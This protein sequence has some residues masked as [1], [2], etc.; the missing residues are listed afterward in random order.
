MKN[1]TFKS[2]IVFAFIL[3][4]S[5]TKMDAQTVT[6]SPNTTQNI[7]TGGT[8]SLTAT[9]SGNNAT[10]PGGNSN[11]TYTWSASPAAGVS[12]TN[13][14]VTIT[15]NNSSTVATF[16]S[17]GT[18]LITCQVQ[19][20]GGGLTATS[21]ATTVIVTSPV[22]SV[23]LTPSGAQNT[24]VGGSISFT[25]AATNFGGSGNYTYTWT[26]AGATIPGSNPNGI[27]GA[28]DTK[29]LTFP[30]AGTFTVSV[31]I[32]RTGATTLT[33]ST[34]TVTVVAANLWASSSTGSQVSSYVVNNGAYIAGPTNLFA[35]SFPGTTTGGT[36]S[37]ALARN[38]TPSA[39]NG[40][41]Y[42]L[43]NTSGNNG[44][45]E[46]FAA[47]STG[48]TPTRIGSVDINGGSNNALGFVRLGVGPDGTAW[49]LAGDNTNLFLASFMTNGINPVTITTK[50]VSLSGGLV[51]TFQNGDVCVSGN[52]N[53]Y[54]LANDGAG[55]TQIFIG[56]LS[57]PTVTLTKKWDLRDENNAA[58]TGTVNGVAFDALG[59]LYIT[60]GSGLY[61]INQA[62]VFG[63][64]VPTVQCSLVDAQTGLQ[65]LASNVFPQ[66]STLPVTLGDF[67]VVRQGSNA[68]L[69][70]TTLT[71]SN[72]DHFEIE[73]SSDGV[74]FSVAGT[75]G[76]GTNSVVIKN[77][78]YIDPINQNSGMIYY[79]LRTVDKDGHGVYSKVITLRIA[80]GLVKD[81]S[82]FPNPFT[83]SLT[84][85]I[86]AEKATSV[87]VR[88]SNA[89]GQPV[90]NR[91][92]ALNQGE[93]TV[94]LQSELQNLKPGM[95]LMEIVSDDGKI[96]Q[97]I[98]KR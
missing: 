59:S 79:R 39:A 1:L 94:V 4:L 32:A 54:A 73:R 36:S 9:R 31:T 50:P 84:L 37:A 26:A 91:R 95:H 61:Y 40:Y 52:N 45:V 46:V 12:F 27:A 72:T 67:N 25:A 43:P 49:L 42:W 97:K 24:T 29:S 88:I 70:W 33:T 90:V 30:T 68:V 57:N 35:F 80:S 83:T 16:A 5:A 21:S 77:Y 85:Q 22:P 60:T 55:V 96:S 66:Q 69:N 82:V 62:T 15:G 48:A 6:L 47:T 63:G 34:A 18:Y 78:Q 65:D 41:F 93:N 51:S 23:S 75:K 92:I 56:S 89:L 28:S 13:N 7:N 86:S 76:S 2:L 19:E 3:V 44:V 20:G 38:A 87:T 81:Y 10:W 58:F 64:P 8:V 74:N 11:F 71:E 53:M 98:I 17:P 14:P